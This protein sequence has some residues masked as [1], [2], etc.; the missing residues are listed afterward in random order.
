MHA[1]AVMGSF[2]TA[3]GKMMPKDECRMMSQDSRYERNTESGCNTNHLMI[4]G[5]LSSRQ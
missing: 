4:T 5:F 2:Q 1:P 3:R